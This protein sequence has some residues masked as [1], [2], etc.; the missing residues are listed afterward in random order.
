MVFRVQLYCKGMKNG[1]FVKN[2][3]SVGRRNVVGAG[4][5]ASDGKKKRQL[6]LAHLCFLKKV[7]SRSAQ[8]DGTC[9]VA[10]CTRVPR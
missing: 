1:T 5:S 6:D 2:E 8:A 3:V 4:A 7:R 10:S 9:Y